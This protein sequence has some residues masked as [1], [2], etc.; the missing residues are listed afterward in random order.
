M[1]NAKAAP[2]ADFT[3]P[4][5]SRCFTICGSDICSFFFLLRAFIAARFFSSRLIPDANSHIPARF[6]S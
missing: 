3:N 6:D 4:M 5:F 2:N 1:A